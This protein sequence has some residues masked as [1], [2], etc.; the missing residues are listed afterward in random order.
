MASLA[1]SS[2][3]EAA[4]AAA[5]HHRNL[6]LMVRSYRGHR[7]SSI[8]AVSTLV[9]LLAPDRG[10]GIHI[11]TWEFTVRLIVLMAITLMCAYRQLA[12]VAALRFPYRF[13]WLAFLLI[14]AT[15]AIVS[16]RPQA[17][18]IFLLY[19]FAPF[20]IG[21]CF[22]SEAPR[23][24]GA[25]RGVV[26]GTVLLSLWAIG[27]FIARRNVFRPE[28]SASVFKVNAGFSHALALSLVLCLGL[29]LVVE[30]SVG[31]P[32]WMR[33][34]MPGIVLV[35]IFVTEERS[36]LIGIAAGVIS[37]MLV[38]VSA[39]RPTARWS[40]GRGRCWSGRPLS[41]LSSQYVQ[42]LSREFNNSGFKCRTRHQLSGPPFSDFVARVYPTTAH[43]L[44]L[45]IH[46][47]SLGKPR[48]VLDSGIPEQIRY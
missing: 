8:T 18:P 3:V 20:Y 27:E 9:L 24:A 30:W 44:G 37:L 15:G 14:A 6:T 26:W 12:G 47:G 17:V 23:L 40:T 32:M 11:G 16:S 38:N 36:P 13:S 2:T 21:A 28:G 43:R 45:W 19:L 1:R 4:A 34:T 42:T 22:G 35:G 5:T 10:V 46:G 48:P 31:H 7:G 29:F 25:L 33:I 39:L 41:R